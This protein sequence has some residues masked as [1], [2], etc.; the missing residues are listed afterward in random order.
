MITNSYHVRRVGARQYLVLL[1][2][3]NSA[4][5][6]VGTHRTSDGA[7][8]Q[9]LA[10]IEMEKWRVSEIQAHGITPGRPVH[11]MD[12]SGPTLEGILT[13]FAKKEAALAAFHDDGGDEWLIKHYGCGGL[14]GFG[15]AYFG[16]SPR[17][18]GWS[19]A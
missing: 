14:A 17:T 18:G 15:P 1:R 12:R 19:A 9:R 2:S 6:V 11:F 8:R 5:V 16:L 7:N 13:L 4:D 3:G 10:E